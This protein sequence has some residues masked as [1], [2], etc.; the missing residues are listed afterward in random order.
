MDKY[1][2]LKRFHHELRLKFYMY[3]LMYVYPETIPEG[4]HFTATKKFVENCKKMSTPVPVSKHWIGF[5]YI[6][7]EDYELD[8]NFDDT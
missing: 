1:A 7:S 6:C 2:Q 3:A 5:C 4:D 8:L